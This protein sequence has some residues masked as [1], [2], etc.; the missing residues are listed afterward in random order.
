[1]KQERRTSKGATMKPLIYIL[2]M[3]ILLLGSL[4]AVHRYIELSR[5]AEHGALTQ[6]YLDLRGIMSE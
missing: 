5:E 4:F 3:G 2:L 6:H 1:M